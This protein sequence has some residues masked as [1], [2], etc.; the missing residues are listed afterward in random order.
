M[1]QF[2]IINNV[3]NFLCSFLNKIP[4]NS[5][6]IRNIFK[7]ES[8]TN[9]VIKFNYTKKRMEHSGNINNLYEILSNPCFLLLTYFYIKK[10]FTTGIITNNGNNITLKSLQILSRKL[11]LSR[12]NNSTLIKIQK[13]NSLKNA[14]ILN[15]SNTRIS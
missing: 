2:Q 15:K 1:T 13:Q 11:L 14:K 10:D 5:E 3:K 6:N 7:V 4:K 12:Y 8:F 9:I